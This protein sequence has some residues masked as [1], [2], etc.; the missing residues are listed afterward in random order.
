VGSL[1][2]RQ[3]G[4][5]FG[6]RGEGGKT[7]PNCRKPDKGPLVPASLRKSGKRTGK[8]RGRNLSQSNI[9][10]LPRGRGFGGD[11]EGQKRKEEDLR[12]FD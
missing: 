4:K 6:S 9:E 12:R 1:Q 10:N 7:F 3:N 5:N 8:G 2:E 11:D